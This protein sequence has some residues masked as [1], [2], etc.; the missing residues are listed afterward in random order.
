MCGCLWEFQP[1]LMLDDVEDLID[2]E[3]QGVEG[4][5]AFGLCCHRGSTL[6]GSWGSM[7]PHT[8]PQAVGLKALGVIK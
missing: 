4:D 1:G 5:G 2:Q 8:F 6:I 3:V 7:P